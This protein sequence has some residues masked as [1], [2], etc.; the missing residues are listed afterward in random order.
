MWQHT[1]ILTNILEYTLKPLILAWFINEFTPLKDIL[2]YITASKLRIV[3]KIPFI[4]ILKI[5]E[6]MMCSSFWVTLILTGNPFV[7]SLNA[8]IG[9]LYQKRLKPFEEWQK[10]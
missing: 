2:Y 9:K 1:V 3:F 5:S 4:L 8:L 7:A 10:I 6:C